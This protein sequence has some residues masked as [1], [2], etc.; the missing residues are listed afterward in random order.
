LTGLLNRRAFHERVAEETERAQR[1]GEKFSLIIIDLDSFKA[2][3]EALGHE[4][5]DDVLRWIGRLLTEQTR[6]A[7]APFRIGGEKF[8]IMAPSAPPE[9]ARA[10]SERIRAVVNETRLR[11]GR[12]VRITVSMGYATCPDHARRAEALFRIAD[13]ALLR[14]KAQGRNRVAGPERTADPVAPPS[15]RAE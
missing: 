5:G 12:G 4:V 3:N 11:L 15:S 10:V 8:A 9:M 7:D 2:V 6:A 14:A 1:Y 13:Q